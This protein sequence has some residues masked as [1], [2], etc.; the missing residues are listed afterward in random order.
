MFVSVL[1]PGS[2]KASEFGVGVGDL[3]TDTSV[4]GSPGSLRDSNFC[5]DNA[6]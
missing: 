3:L 1:F 2:C 4:V 6:P 5:I